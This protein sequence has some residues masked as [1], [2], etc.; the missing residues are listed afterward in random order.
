LWPWPRDRQR[1]RTLAYARTIRYRSHSW[2]SARR[3]SINTATQAELEAL[4]GVGPVIARRI[5]EGR[6]YRSVEELERV[7]GIGKKRLD[8]FRSLVT[9]K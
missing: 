4:P 9:V 6:P 5:I 8:E 2:T 7:K 3:I 1:P